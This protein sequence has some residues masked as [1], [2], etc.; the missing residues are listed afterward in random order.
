MILSL[1]INV[2]QPLKPTCE[3][4]K[5]PVGVFMRE[6]A[7]QFAGKSNQNENTFCFPINALMWMILLL[8]Y[9][10]NFPSSIRKVFLLEICFWFFPEEMEKEINGYYA[11]GWKSPPRTSEWWH[12]SNKG[13]E[14]ECLSRFA[15]IVQTGCK[16]WDWNSWFWTSVGT[17]FCE[18]LSFVGCVD[19]WK[20]IHFLN[21]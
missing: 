4:A 16:V 9:L 18:Q 2:S 10:A 14:G 12:S 1:N 5:A 3:C 7:Y 8:E 17:F 6:Q 11:R 13:M 15:A 19:E 21:F 20:W